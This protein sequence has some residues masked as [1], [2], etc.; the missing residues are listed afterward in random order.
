LRNGGL[1]IGQE[2]VILLVMKSFRTELQV[3]TSTTQIRHN[4]PVFTIGSCFAESIGKR[5]MNNKFIV[6]ANPFG[7]LYNPVSIH[8]VL[9]YALHNEL[10]QPTTY[11]KNQEIWCNYEFHS[12]LSDVT[13][14]QL[15]KKISNAI[16]TAHHFLKDADTLIITYGTAKVYEQV[17]TGEPVANCH[18]MPAGNFTS[19]ILKPEKITESFEILFEKL[20]K[21][22][23]G[24]KI[25]LTV[26][27]VRHIKD[28][29][30][31]NSVSKSALRWACHAIQERCPSVEYF[32]AYEIMMDDLRDYRFYG[33][34]MIHPSG[35]AMDYIWEKFSDAYFNASTKALMK[36]WQE[37]SAAL[38]HRPFHPKSAAHKKFL[39]ETLRKLE[40]LKT[41]IP[42]KEEIAHIRSQLPKTA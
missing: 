4:M 7:T 37:V 26:S 24:I 18:K 11:I 31:F 22:K 41:L 38:H 14:G 28:T 5:L 1:P 40:E 3:K 2:Q 29:P 19:Q 34:D 42:V 23:P 17:D 27:P 6:S 16:G 32:P 9:L 13:K 35:E 21:W 30:E 36:Q 8:K 39:N 25:M 15:E 20:K 12:S 33:A 10:P